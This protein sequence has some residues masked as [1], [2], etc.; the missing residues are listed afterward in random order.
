M[1]TESVLIGQIS[2]GDDDGLP[3]KWPY[4]CLTKKI[5]D[6]L[7]KITFLGEVETEIWSGIKTSFAFMAF[8]MTDA[9]LSLLSSL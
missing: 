6:R 7:I 8:S 4:W 5:Q 1:R 9:S 3:D 2:V